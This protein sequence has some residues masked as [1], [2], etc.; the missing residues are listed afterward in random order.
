MRFYR[1]KILS[2]EHKADYIEIRFCYTHINTGMPAKILYEPFIILLNTDG[3]LRSQGLEHQ[4][5]LMCN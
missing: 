1:I 2:I 3:L 4:I 5:F